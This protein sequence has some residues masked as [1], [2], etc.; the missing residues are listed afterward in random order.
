M[1]IGCQWPREWQKR[2][3][4]KKISSST[5]EKKAEKIFLDIDKDKAGREILKGMMV[6]RFVPVDDAAYRSVRE[7][8][9]RIAAQ[10]SNQGNRKP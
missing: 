7:M 4:Q 8:K 5:I 2:D 10:K 9:D 3:P 6:D 1:L